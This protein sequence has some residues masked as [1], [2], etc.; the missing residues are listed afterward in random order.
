M[1]LIC[2]VNPKV[3]MPETVRGFGFND[4]LA[5]QNT[6][7]PSDDRVFSIRELMMMTV[8]SSFKWVEADLE[9]LN[10]LSPTQKRAFLK[11]EEIKIR[12]SLGE[13]VPTAIFQAIA[14][15]IAAVLKCRPINN[16]TIKKIVK[17][18]ELSDVE[19]L[20]NFI[21]QNSMSL[22]AADLGKIAELANT[23]R[24]D[25]TAFFTSKT[26]ITEMMKEA[27]IMWILRFMRIIRI[28]GHGHL[29]NVFIS[30]RSR[31]FQS[32]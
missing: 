8:P 29:K 20:K 19:K 28:K 11:K 5:S 26:L 31:V 10:Q 27:L 24:T 13:A 7:H 1:N 17:E 4:Q 30:K 23:R 16:A 14:K 25:N 21:E 9:S 32:A 18:Y 6:I 12:Q 3:V 15:K 2:V 22:S